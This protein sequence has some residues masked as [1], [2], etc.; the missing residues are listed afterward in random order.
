MFQTRPTESDVG[1]RLLSR[2]RFASPGPL[3]RSRAARALAR[4]L[5]VLL[6][7]HPSGHLSRS[8]KP[9]SSSSAKRNTARSSSGRTPVSRT[10]AWPHGEK[11]GTD[12]EEEAVHVVAVADLLRLR[13]EVVTVSC[14]D[15]ER[16]PSPSSC[17]G[18]LVGERR[19]DQ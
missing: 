18:R 12:V 11:F 7:S 14:R 15:V 4:D 16:R 19:T 10:L 3:Y 2:R 5:P 9:F 17:Q 8:R 6:F 13:H 1:R